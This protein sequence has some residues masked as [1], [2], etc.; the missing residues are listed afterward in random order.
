MAPA[1]TTAATPAARERDDLDSTW[2]YLEKNIDNVMWRLEEGL[3]MKTYMGVY[4]AVHNFC[5]SQK[6]VNNLQATGGTLANH[7]G[8]HLLGE[9]LYQLLGQ[10]LTDHLEGV[11]KSASSHTD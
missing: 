10:Y 9:E 8:A 2:T 1:R 4:T 5:T 11:A 3:D 7:R 6:A